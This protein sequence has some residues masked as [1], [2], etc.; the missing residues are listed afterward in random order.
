MAVTAPPVKG[1]LPLEH[2]IAGLAIEARLKADRE[3]DQ[4][5]HEANRPATPARLIASNAYKCHRQEAF[6]ILRVPKSVE[7]TAQQIMTFAAGDF[8][9]QI[10]GEAV[11]QWLDAR[12]EV[13][14]DL[15][16]DWDAYGRVDGL[17]TIDPALLPDHEP[18][19]GLIDDLVVGEWK[20]QA[21]FGFDLAVGNRRSD[22]GPG[23]KLDHLI[24]AG[25]GAKGLRA[26]WAHIV[27]LNKDRGT[28]AEWL[29]DVL[30]PLPHVVA[31]ADRAEL[32]TK[33]SDDA[34]HPS[35]AWLVHWDLKRRTDQ[36]LDVID[37]GALPARLIPAYGL[38]DF[39]PPAPGTRDKPWQCAYCSWQPTCAALAHDQIDGWV[40]TFLTTKEVA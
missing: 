33:A 17:Y 22:E 14:F 19:D 39:D 18:V 8:Y 40:E 29:I 13:D 10:A 11:V 20:S 16:P 15:R 31:V 3:R 7:Y 6:S 24:Q 12:L 36:V 34:F 4:A 30:A 23:P 35:I 32:N 1:M 9:G 37:V 27:Y 28:C 38:V 21:G 5:E 25:T 26:R 2:P